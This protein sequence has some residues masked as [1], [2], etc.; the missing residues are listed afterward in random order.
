M[1]STLVREARHA[2]VRNP[3]A[4]GLCVQATLTFSSIGFGRMGLV[5]LC[6]VLPCRAQS[7]STREGVAHQRTRPY[8][9]YRSLPGGAGA[10]ARRQDLT[11]G[12]I[13]GAVG[14]S[15]Q[16]TRV[17]ALGEE[18]VGRPAMPVRG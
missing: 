3:E 16:G 1:D 17:I 11:N 10:C 5:L 9:G 2:G 8:F 18:A 4:P 6:G 13:P 15:W 7:K 12:H 14:T